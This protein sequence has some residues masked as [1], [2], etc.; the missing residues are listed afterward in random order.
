MERQTMKK[1]EQ[2]LSDSDPTRQADV[3]A[4][5]VPERGQG[6]RARKKTQRNGGQEHPHLMKGGPY[7]SKKLDKQVGSTQRELH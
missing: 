5:D 6:G 2:S 4:A 1:R 7:K 3:P